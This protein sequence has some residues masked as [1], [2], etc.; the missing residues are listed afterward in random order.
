MLR[1]LGFC[2]QTA[3]D[4]GFDT[5]PGLGYKQ[6][7]YSFGSPGAPSFRRGEVSA[8]AGSYFACLVLQISLNVLYQLEVAFRVLSEVNVGLLN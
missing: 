2:G 6:N 3:L 1:S 4:W 8:S 5:Y 7:W